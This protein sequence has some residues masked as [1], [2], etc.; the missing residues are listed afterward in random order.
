MCYVNTI[1]FTKKTTSTKMEATP[2]FE[3]LIAMS[4]HRPLGRSSSQVAVHP[5][6]HGWPHGRRQ[7]P[8]VA[9]DRHESV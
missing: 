9:F 2:L 7:R 1:A 6:D 4:Q 3:T 8:R 5:Y